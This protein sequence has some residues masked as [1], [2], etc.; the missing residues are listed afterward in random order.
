MVDK[1]L[2]ISETEIKQRVKELGEAIS[3]DYAGTPLV[4]IG[5][6]NGAFIFMADLARQITM[7]VEIDFVRASSYG[8]H[9][10]SSGTISFTKD[11]ELD[12]TD[13]NVLL[14]EDIV[15]TGNT[16]VRLKEIFAARNPRSLKICTLINKTERRETKVEIDYHGFTIEHGF[17]VGYGLDY[18][19]QH[20]HYPEIH[21]LLNPDQT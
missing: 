15:D 17:L 6:L 13:K 5:I 4:M 16:I 20:R 19:E 9:S 2:V 3:K 1:K 21:H 12:I 14:I 8:E 10:Y 11:V 7:P 18:A